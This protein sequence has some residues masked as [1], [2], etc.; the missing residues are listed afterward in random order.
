MGRGA[1]RTVR[2]WAA[3]LVGILLPAAGFAAPGDPPAPAAR[4]PQP[5]R[6]VTR[7]P[8]PADPLEQWS[9]DPVP[10]PA[11]VSSVPAP[12]PGIPDSLAAS[13][14]APGSRWV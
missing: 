4:N 2:T 5:Q 11:A 14:P 13:A 8:E 3:G 6:T 10:P 12:A 1:E 9:L 7:P